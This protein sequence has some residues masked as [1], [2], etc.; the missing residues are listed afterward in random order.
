MIS[1]TILVVAVTLFAFGTIGWVAGWRGEEALFGIR[2]SP[3][4]MQSEGRTLLRRFRWLLAGIVAPAAILSAFL[5]LNRHM[6]LQFALYLALFFLVSLLYL[7]YARAVERHE[8]TG[9]S[10]PVGA[11]LGNR[12]PQSFGLLWVAIV[13]WLLPVG[14]LSLWWYFYP[15]LPQTYPVHWDFEGHANGWATKSIASA[16]AT[17]VLAFYILGFLALIKRD[18]PLMKITLPAE[19][20]ER[21]LQQRLSFIRMNYRFLD[22]MGLLISALISLISASL[23]LS[24]TQRLIEMRQKPFIVTFVAVIFGFVLFVAATV[25]RMVKAFYK[26]Q[27]TAKP[28]PATEREQEHWVGGGTLYCNPDDPA[29]FVEKRAGI[30]GTV[31][32]AHPRAKLYGAY[33]LLVPL[34]VWLLTTR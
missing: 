5:V 21:Y 2:V 29:L 15:Q 22:I 1:L 27:Q 4:Y 18:L 16:L 26:L 19:D 9:R 6:I 24:A 12:D 31:N 33:L 32:L 10:G 3:E 8:V 13:S 14:A 7:H 25:V 17:P 23:V 20:A 34:L 28:L 30:G 11:S